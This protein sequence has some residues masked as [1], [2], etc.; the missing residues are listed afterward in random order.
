MYATTGTAA[1]F[2][3]VWKEPQMDNGER[4][5]EKLAAVVSQ[6]LAEDVVARISST[7]DVKP[8]ALTGNRLVTE[9]DKSL[10]SL[11]RPERLLDLAGK[12]T[13]FDGGIKKVARYQQYFVIKSTLKRVK[14]FDS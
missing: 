11:C 8:E 13:V 10:F 4:E 3:G 7:F 12:F 5:F 9:Q 2:W 14:H 1:K 6:P